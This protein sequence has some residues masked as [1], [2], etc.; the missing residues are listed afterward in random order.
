MIYTL[1]LTGVSLVYVGAVLFINGLWLLDKL[2]RKEVIFV[3]SF[4]GLISFLIAFHL[5]FSEHADAKTIEAGAYT[6]LFSCTYLW[7]AFNQYMQNDGRGLGW[8]CLFVSIITVPVTISLFIKANSVWEVWFSFCWGSW[9]I[10]WFVYFINLV[11]LQINKKYV[12]MLTL[13]TSIISAW[14]PGYL[15]ISGVLGQ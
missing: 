8:F 6:F 7:V 4:V 15:L 13:V 2:D 14:I 9:G 12:G 1:N 5:V 11:F 10:L 3:D